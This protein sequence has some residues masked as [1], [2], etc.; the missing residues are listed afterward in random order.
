MNL[1]QYRPKLIAKKNLVQPVLEILVKM[2]AKDETT[3]G[4]L[5]SFNAQHAHATEED[6][7]DDDDF[8]PELEWQQLA[9][10]CLDSMSINIPSKYFSQPALAV[11]AQVPFLSWCS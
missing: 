1:L 5:Y 4:T 3:A 2:I 9:Q 11:C 8:S 7:D 10:T 6:D